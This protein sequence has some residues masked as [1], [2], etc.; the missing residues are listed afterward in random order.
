[1]G[2]TIDEFLANTEPTSNAPTAPTS[3]ATAAPDPSNNI[4]RWYTQADEAAKLQNS[5]QRGA[6]KDPEVAA[7]VL[8]L[9][10]ETGMA[11]D[12]IE[13][14]LQ[15]IEDEKKKNTFDPVKFQ[16]TA[17]IT[18][19]WLS[20]DPNHVA[21]A[22]EDFSNLNY[23]ERQWNYITSQFHA[24]R[25]QNEL[26]DIGESA[27]V[28]T[29]TP[30]QRARQAEIQNELAKQSD[31][32]ITGFAAQV[33]GVVANALPMFG[34]TFVG[35]AEAAGVGAVAGAGLGAVEGLAGG[36]AAEV[37]V[38]A[39]ALAQGAV[40][41]GLGWRYGSAVAMA[42]MQTGLSY[43]DFEKIK[44]ENGNAID[45]T[46]AKGAAAIVGVGQGLLE[47]IPFEAAL[48]KV[49]GLNGITAKG[50]QKLLESP[51]TRQAFLG[52]AKHVGEITAISGVSNFFQEYMK[53]AAT[54]VLEMQASD[55]P[56]STGAVMDRLFNSEILNKSLTAGKQGL[57]VGL[58]LGVATGA[59][60]LQQNL[61]QVR[62]AEATK[63][64]FTN[65]GEGIKNSK[66][67]ERAPEKTEELVS[68]LTK[69]TPSE[70]VYIPVDA[71]TSYWQDKKVDPAD[72]AA[73]ILGDSKSY[74]E[75]QRTGQ[76]L[77]IP[78]AKYATK[79]APTQHNSFFVNELKTSP[80]QMNARE[81]SEFVQKLDREDLSATLKDQSPEE[82]SAKKVHEDVVTQLKSTGM[83]DSTAEQYGQ[84][85][86][87]A[88]KTLG[89]RS[90]EDPFQL[91]DQ[92]GL[93]IT[94][95]ELGALATED[96]QV[97]EQG[98]RI[99]DFQKALDEKKNAQIDSETL[100]AEVLSD[101][102]EKAGVTKEMVSDG[103]WKER[104]SE[105][106]A[107]RDQQIQQ[108]V[109]ETTHESLDGHLERL[110]SEV[111][112][113]KPN[114]SG[115]DRN[116]F[117]EIK[118]E[119]EALE[120]KFEPT[121]FAQG[122]EGGA[123][124][125]IEIGPNRQ[126][127]INLLK[128]ADLSTFLHESGHFYL[129]VLGDLATKKDANELLKAD[130]QTILDH[131]GVKD[132][133][134]I[135]TDQHENFARS[136]E[137]YLMEGKAPTPELRTAFSRFRAWMVSIYKQL[138]NLN[139]KLT[140]PVRKVFDRLLASEEEINAAEKNSSMQPL[141]SD[142]KAFGMSE[143]EAARYT[144]AI[145][146]A[147]V[148]AEDHL[149]QK[150]VDEV[151]RE[152]TKVYKEAK[153]KIKDQVSQEVNADPLYI[154][155]S[156]LQKG[157]LP[158]GDPL[159]EGL[160]P[161]KLSK[162]ALLQDY[163]KNFLNK[164]PK[165]FI[166]AAKGGVHPDQVAGLFGFHSGDE[167]LSQ[168]INAEK[169]ETKIDRLVGEK[170]TERFGDMRVDGRIH[171]E[172]LT[173]IHND[174]RSELLRKELEYLTS[175]NLAAFKGLV[176]KVSRPIPTLESVRSQAELTI[177]G[178][179]FRDLSPISYERAGARAG[180]EAV[181]LL[182]KGDVEGAFEAKQRELLNNELYRAASNAKDSVEKMTDY[183][184]KFDSTDVRAKLG[185]AGEDYL[186]QIDGI[187][188]R[189]D[190][191]KS[192]SLKAID[193]RK[194]LLSWVISQ[195]K[196]GYELDLPEKLLNE[197]YRQHYKDTTVDELTGVRDSVQSIEHL[198]SL[199][200]KLLKNQEF[201]DFNE[202]KAAVLASIS[203][204][205]DLTKE[206][207][208]PIAPNLKERLVKGGSGVVALHAR[209]EFIFRHLDG[210]KE[211]GAAWKN[212]FDPMNEAEAKENELHHKSAEAIKEIFS[213][214]SGQETGLFGFKKTYVP[215]VGQSFTK[216]NMLSVALN[217]GNAYNK[218]ALMRG[219]KWSESQ[220]QAIVKH[221]DERDWKVVQKIL[222]HI[223]SYWPQIEA[224]EKRLNGIA[225]EKVAA[226]S[227]KTP[228]G[229]EMR[230]GYYPI[231]FDHNRSEKQ[232]QLDARSDVQD[233]MGGNFARA[234][235]KKGHTEA[236]ND[237]GGKPLSLELSGVEKHLGQVIHDLS[238][239]EAVIDVNK[240][241][242]D[243]DI[244]EAIQKAAG[245]DM[246]RQ[247][248]PWLVDI[249]GDRPRDPMNYI[250]RLIGKARSGVT[251]VNLG[252]K[253]TSA[254]V[255]TS[256]YLFAVK[257]VGPV[258]SLKG[259]AET[260]LKPWNLK[261]T[262]EFATSRSD[263]MKERLTLNERDIRDQARASN[264]S[265]GSGAKSVL[266]HYVK[267]IQDVAFIPMGLMDLGTTLP[268]WFSGY[269]K[270]MEG[271]VDGI[272][273]GNEIDA[274]KYADGLVRRT[275]GSGS[276]KDLSGVQRGPEVTKLMTMF[277][278]PASVIFN[279]FLEAGQSYRLEKNIPKLVGT[280]GMIWFLPAIM[281]QVARGRTPNL[282]D[283]DASEWLSWLAKTELLYPAESVVLMPGILP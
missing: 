34:K 177:G 281:Q 28:G 259:I 126:M 250:E 84:L 98:A 63:Q 190:F 151:Q 83:T 3:A 154:A 174:Q 202:A 32:G 59:P 265:G 85:Y 221:L 180:K 51:T 211:L 35:K 252:F 196:Q 244:R 129:E 219:Y 229:S 27:F 119:V 186:D 50:V 175:E 62:E 33:P 79:I 132:R 14:N 201:K 56:L 277:Y 185:K 245:Q 121:Q 178:K 66:L 162:E 209:P 227:F 267:P 95:P 106:E 17:P 141:F 214:Y 207:M 242:K 69:D 158:N 44:D 255:H 9:Q 276:T 181:D 111:D 179:R 248:N 208:E 77:Q 192:T 203:A 220:V 57:Q 128:G 224:M 148:S 251:I 228:L 272:K 29:I 82:L 31:Y 39:A 166:Y 131:L 266:D 143:A 144:K 241:L 45:S 4:V 157:V 11:P 225:P 124:G 1:V 199:K 155:L 75:A 283:A 10:K 120:A 184:S 230:G 210:L 237:T 102:M 163:D 170:L 80:E 99:L 108:S 72:V 233:L 257:E 218:E 193:K 256:N 198:A 110:T 67:N 21:V 86:S 41:A 140:D 217:L 150:L 247:L 96:T 263:L 130:F 253:V 260:L 236:R 246:Y 172:A 249:A 115:A 113:L 8:Q 116:R 36:P 161:I 270:A 118:K 76:D 18:S 101:K 30:E 234:M 167:M 46:T 105:Y 70:N 282:Q 160:H 147:R 239:R 5:M 42:R 194:D 164:L 40:G 93:K 254:L 134:E 47:F 122:G 188:E 205:H 262:F 103:T 60:E 215:E 53:D 12:F 24:G 64:V 6:T 145:Q 117:L 138:K 223:D 71:W 88:F 156:I 191:K 171:E 94:R 43:L 182:L 104:L 52:Y 114:E 19:S 68:R 206:T 274:V 54:Q 55:K 238:F 232:F 168:M 183:F 92:Y 279:Q 38:P 90:G 7:R 269:R 197:A 195:K 123:R 152:K 268:I 127:N 91:Y 89:K 222:D 213:A 187:L 125:Q 15:G 216:R 212:M 137:A 109:D 87:S 16:Q 204:H 240:F 280:M 48:S 61:N 135:G 226:E 169:R 100:T 165:P 189:Y 20:E 264:L 81:A 273:L 159:P 153:V 26:S 261:E 133:S 2:Q 275:K 112:T 22:N 200:F 65:L 13:R 78:T 74:D 235:T 176:K 173:A 58:G 23:L 278:S 107:S 231:L 136:F 49:P 25:L 37:T 258:Y 271:Q 146:E 97:F 142:P 243:K 149:S 73:E 139:V